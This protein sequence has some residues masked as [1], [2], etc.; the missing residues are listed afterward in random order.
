MTLRVPWPLLFLLVLFPALTPGPLVGQTQKAT[1]TITS[2]A[3]THSGRTGFVLSQDVDGHKEITLSFGSL[4]E[5]A[6]G[7]P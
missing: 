1:G 6:V 3:T 7:V 4:L 5:D 2:F